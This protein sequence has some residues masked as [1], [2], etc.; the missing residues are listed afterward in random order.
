MIIL[1]RHG[2]ADHNVKKV[3]DSNIE[4]KSYLTDFGIEQVKVS[5]NKLIEN[6]YEK[7]YKVDRI[8]CSPLVRTIQSARIMRDIL[9]DNGLFKDDRFCIDYNLR[10]IEM[11]T[12]DG[13]LVSDYPHGYEFENNDEFGG[14]N[15]FDVQ[16]RVKKFLGG[17]NQS[18]VNLIVTHGEPF[19][20]MYYN[21]LKKDIY[22][23]R[24]QIVI[25]DTYN[26]QLLYD[27]QQNSK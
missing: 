17:L 20:R 23:K 18:N 12:F 3:F 21:Y 7:S 15:T 1:I 8:Y 13:R 16:K 10:E 5:T 25:I 24:S 9:F 6:L 4:S 11:G 14:E 19:R 26:K 27:S 22:P 2:E